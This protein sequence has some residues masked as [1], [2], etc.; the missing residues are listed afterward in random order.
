M[1]EKEKALLLFKS[2]RGQYLIGQALWYAIR[3][4]EK[5]KGVRKE[6]NNIEDMKLLMDN[7]FDMFQTIQMARAFDDK[8]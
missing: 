4:L 8:G 5:V 7:L 3:E 1:S 2:H 6:V